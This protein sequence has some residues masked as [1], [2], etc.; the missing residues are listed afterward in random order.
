MPVDQLK[1]VHTALLDCVAGLRSSELR[2]QYHPDLSPLGWH[3]GHVAYIGQYWLD[4]VILD[5]DD[6]TSGKDAQ[7]LPERIDK[8]SRKKLAGIDDLDALEH[9][10][11]D[12][13]ATLL[14]LQTNKQA[15]QLMN[16]DYIGW[17]LVQHAAQHHETM[18]MVLQQ[19][20][21]ILHDDE[22]LHDVDMAG[23]S[24]S[25]PPAIP[26][27]QVE[28]GSY[29]IGSHDVLAYDNEC[30]GHDAQ[31]ETFLIAPRPVSNAQYLGFIDVGGYSERRYWSDAG[32]QWKTS[33][34]VVAPQHWH[35]VS[36]KWIQSTPF[37]FDSLEPDDAVIGLAWHE[38]EAFAR[39]A[40]ARLPH[41]NE[42]EIVMSLHP[43]LDSST[44]GGWE[45]C[46][47]TLYPY[48]GFQAF[49][50]ERYSQP[51]FDGCHYVM[52]GAGPYT[53]TLVRR[54]SFRNFYLADKRYAF[55]GLR[56][57]ADA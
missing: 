6:K 12:I 10:Y 17:F 31:I 32:W 21:L 40:G 56:L 29:P 7:F 13:E 20:Q 22:T 41:E 5:D 11:R 28:K 35:H 57:A 16:D 8:K 14:A 25:E 23:L 55:S 45:W 4:E 47:N 49:P 19:R 37:G 54:P 43:E 38:A 9:M 52:R 24:T 1:Q 2:K 3:L 27:L 46:S 34:G 51:W 42:W 44:G 33:H 30:P 48:D 53:N 39:Y 18:H 36:G 15:H 26:S 50:Y